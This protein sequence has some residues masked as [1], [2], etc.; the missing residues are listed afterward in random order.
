MSELLEKD[1]SELVQIA[2][3]VLELKERSSFSASIR[4]NLYKLVEESVETGCKR[5]WRR[6]HKHV[7]NP[8]EEAIL[9]AIQSEV[10]GAISEYV[11]L[12]SG[13]W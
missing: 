13:D 4:V 9:E 5:G 8:S 1:V 6:A 7:D 3:S 11:N 10:M 12:S 2:R